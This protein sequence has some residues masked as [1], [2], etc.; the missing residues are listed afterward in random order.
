MTR[1]SVTRNSVI[2]RLGL[3]L[4]LGLA[5]VG[6]TQCRLVS[7]RIT[8]VELRTPQGLNE[9]SACV[10]RC[11]DEFEAGMA[12]AEARFLAAIQ[13]CGAD[14]ACRIAAT[15]QHQLDVQALVDVR[16][17]CKRGCYNEGSGRGH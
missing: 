16:L 4:A 7:D 8:G 12:A 9:R 14:T 13:A 11:N 1:N 5:L 15:T 2:P 3:A 10:Q 6:A 17:D